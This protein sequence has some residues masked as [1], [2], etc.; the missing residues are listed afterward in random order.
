MSTKQEQKG[1]PW[2]KVLFF[3]GVLILI[4]IAIVTGSWVVPVLIIIGTIFSYG[5]FACCCGV[6]SAKQQAKNPDK[7]DSSIQDS[8]YTSSGITAGN[9]LQ[10]ETSTKVSAIAQRLKAFFGISSSKAEDTTP[11]AVIAAPEVA[12]SQQQNSRPHSELKAA[13]DKV[14]SSIP[15]A[16]NTVSA[17][18]T[19]Q[20][21][22]LSLSP[23]PENGM[24]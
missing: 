21:S 15:P 3:V 14:F 10:M 18:A 1:T 7:L 16:T 11:G 5:L 6:G 17:P 4:G 19:F 22:N 13:F 23:L 24:R 9:N 2:E 8:T 12:R 20:P